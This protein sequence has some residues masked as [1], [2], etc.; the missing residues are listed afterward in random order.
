[1]SQ[2]VGAEPSCYAK[3]ARGDDSRLTGPLPQTP[4]GG[5]VLT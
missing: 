3:P 2:R 4:L 1:M 5:I